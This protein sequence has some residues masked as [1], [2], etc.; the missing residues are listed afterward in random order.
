MSQNAT[1]NVVLLCV[2]LAFCALAWWRWGS[3]TRPGPR[4]L[5]G[6]SAALLLVAVTA[7]AGALALTT[8]DS[9]GLITALAAGA[10]GVAAW[11]T[12]KRGAPAATTVAAETDP[13]AGYTVR[14]AAERVA[15]QAA[16]RPRQPAYVSPSAAVRAIENME[17]E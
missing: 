1:L 8:P 12:V 4:R 5:L 6:V 17:V 10:V 16:Q 13:I 2:W 7:Q 3:M 11:R 14:S 15:Q 9:R